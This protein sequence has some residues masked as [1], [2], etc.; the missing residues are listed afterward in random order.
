M[1]SVEF[2]HG[3]DRYLYERLLNMYRC[4]LQE[5]E[6]AVAK[7]RTRTCY[8]PTEIH[9]EKAKRKYLQTLAEINAARKTC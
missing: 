3:N 9:L 5:L 1:Y 7:L 4:C 8:S 2:E 6:L